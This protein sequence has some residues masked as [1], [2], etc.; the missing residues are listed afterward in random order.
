[1]RH[2]CPLLLL[3]CSAVA[4]AAT[5]PTDEHSIARVQ[6]RQFDIQ[7]EINADARP[8]QSIELWYTFDG[9]ATWQS[10][11]LDPDNTPPVNVIAPQE[12]LCGLYIVATNAVGASG[13]TPSADTQP[14]QW[15]FIDFTPP[16][17]QFHEPKVEQR[18]GKTVA[19]LSWT[20][21]DANL[22]DRPIDI[23][24]RAL[25]DGAWRSIASHLPNSGRY[26][27]FVPDDCGRRLMFRLSVQDRGGHRSEAATGAVELAAAVAQADAD[28]PDALAARA[29]GEP[30]DTARVPTRSERIRA[31]EL[32][33]KGTWHELRGEHELAVARL[34]DSLKLEPHAPD[35]LVNLGT[36]LYA[37]GRYEEAA[38]AIEL[39]LRQRPENAAALDE[40]AKTFIALQRYDAAEASL[41]KIV[42][43]DPNATRAWLNLGDVA[44]YRGSE[45][46]AREYYEKAATL[47][48]QAA[49]I[50]ARARARLDDLP[51]LSSRYQASESP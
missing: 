4:A 47:Q 16:V 18:A 13:P 50:V 40:L 44:I 25:P 24:C 15:V 10:Y 5:P 11:G 35:V 45:I 12:G 29:V 33:R 22:I 3:V 28:H 26:D 39:S 31:Q 17:C 27:W 20:A 46:D 38:G 21:I 2:G 49:D 14:Q 41:L 36:A 48:P 34:R 32:T 6:T 19:R 23:A 51:A 42:K 1:M 9:G 43:Q 8:L 7:Y 30:I 37:L